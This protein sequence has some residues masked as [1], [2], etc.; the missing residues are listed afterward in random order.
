MRIPGRRSRPGG[1]PDRERARGALLAAERA[2]LLSLD[3]AGTQPT[4]RMSPVVQA[5]IRAATP[6]GMR[7]RA[8]KAAADALLEVWPADDLQSVAGRGPAVVCGQP[9]AGGW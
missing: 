6:D 7:D 2:G 5:A 9:A 1:P 4:V 3:L 8:V